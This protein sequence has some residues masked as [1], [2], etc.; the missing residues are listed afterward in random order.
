MRASIPSTASPLDGAPRAGFGRHVH[1]LEMNGEDD[2]RPSRCSMQHARERLFSRLHV[3]SS[4]ASGF[5]G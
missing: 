5:S 4:F 2:R 3:R 1:I